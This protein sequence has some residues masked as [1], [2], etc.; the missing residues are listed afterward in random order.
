MVFDFVIYLK[1]DILDLIYSFGSDQEAK[2]EGDLV[3]FSRR[4]DLL[5]HMHHNLIMYDK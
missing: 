2:Q 4:N 1:Q 3:D 5:N